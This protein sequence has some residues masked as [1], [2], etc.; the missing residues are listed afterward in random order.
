MNELLEKE[1][2]FLLVGSD[3]LTP[4]QAKAKAITT[5]L[6]RASI[7]T[8]NMT[9]EEQQHTFNKCFCSPIQRNF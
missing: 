2:D 5:L 8:E 7:N 6:E 1:M 4:S 9:P 3:T